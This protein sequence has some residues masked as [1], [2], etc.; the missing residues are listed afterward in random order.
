MNW[1]TNCKKGTADLAAPRSRNDTTPNTSRECEKQA[2]IETHCG[3]SIVSGL[4]VLGV[5]VLT[6]ALVFVLSRFNEDGAWT[7]AERF[8][9]SS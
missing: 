1:S 2:S 7:L 5:A 4:D 9:V 3:D 6:A 8:P